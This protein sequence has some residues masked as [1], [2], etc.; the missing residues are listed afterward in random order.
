MAW[1]NGNE[2]YSLAGIRAQARKRAK[3]AR[4][5]SKRE[6][7]ASFDDQVESAI[8]AG[9]PITIIPYQG[10]PSYNHAK[11]RKR[12]KIAELEATI[13]T[14]KRE[15]PQAPVYR[16]G[17]G[18]E[19]Y[20]TREWRSLRFDVIRA[21]DGKCKL[22]GRSRDDGIIIHV[23]HIKP[24]SKHPLLELLFENLQVLCEDCNLGKSNK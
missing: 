8:A 14:L 22:C 2:I 13:A 4:K 19:F 20:Q 12:D 7:Q 18:S 1:G 5:A 10:K 24:R 9:I 21:S 6:K 11:P 3:I 17:M 15:R 23:D 16:P